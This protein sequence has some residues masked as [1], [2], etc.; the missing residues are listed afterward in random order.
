MRTTR[1]FLGKS[2]QVCCSKCVTV[3]SWLCNYIA[4]EL[5][6][7]R[8]CLRRNSASIVCLDHSSCDKETELGRFWAHFQQPCT[9]QFL[10]WHREKQAPAGSH[11]SQDNG[12]TTNY[13]CIRTHRAHSRSEPKFWISR[14]EHFRN[15]RQWW[16]CSCDYQNHHGVDHLKGTDQCELKTNCFSMFCL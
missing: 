13:G 7:L 4:Q 16:H 10:V 6:S 15:I 14:V 2:R 1:Y 11:L 5:S 9:A 3:G 8:A 12:K